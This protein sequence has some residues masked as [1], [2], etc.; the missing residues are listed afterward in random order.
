VASQTGK[1][2]WP[3][4][5]VYSASKFGVIGLTQVAARELGPQGVCAQSRADAPVASRARDDRHFASETGV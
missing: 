3:L 5:G 2:G 1:T 4:L